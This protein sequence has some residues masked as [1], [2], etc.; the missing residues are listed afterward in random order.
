MRLLCCLLCRACFAVCLLLLCL[1]CSACFA[2]CCFCIMTAG[3]DVISNNTQR[4]RIRCCA[5]APVLFSITT[6]CCAWPAFFGQFLRAILLKNAIKRNQAMMQLETFFFVVRADVLRV[7]CVG[8]QT[9]LRPSRRRLNHRRPHAGLGSATGRLTSGLAVRLL[10]LCTHAPAPPRLLC[11]RGNSRKS[12]ST[13][14]QTG[15]FASPRSLR[16]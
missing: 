4:D 11:D 10:C 5:P 6:A 7:V 8:R 12:M 16:N 13:R 2:A 15:P 1:P 14:I 9:Q 3:R